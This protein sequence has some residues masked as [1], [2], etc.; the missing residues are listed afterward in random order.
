MWA[1]MFTI[2]LCE[3]RV[4]WYCL[5]WVGD[6]SYDIIFWHIAI[7]IVI[8]SSLKYMYSFFQYG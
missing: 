1:D 2:K 4:G 3:H 8:I 7:I 6:Y 5:N